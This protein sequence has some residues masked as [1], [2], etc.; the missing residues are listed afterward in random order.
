MKEELI[1]FET[2][3]LA[4]EVGFDTPTWF[5][6][7]VQGTVSE[8][9]PEGF[10]G[11]NEELWQTNSTHKELANPYFLAS[12]PT[13]SLLQ[14]WLREKHKVLVW[15]KPIPSVGKWSVYVD[16]TIG[17]HLV[18]DYIF[19]DTYEEA[20]EAGLLEALKLIKT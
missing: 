15:I 17:R 18:A 10:A 19:K 20:L 4:K 9:L 13:Q 1:S 16:D 11:L 5:F 2:A 6:Y 12:A 3:K 14:R 7:T 8:H